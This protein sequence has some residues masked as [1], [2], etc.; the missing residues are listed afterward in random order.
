MWQRLDS[1]IGDKFKK[2][3]AVYDKN[4]GKKMMAASLRFMKYAKKVKVLTRIVEGVP[5]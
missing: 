4:Y 5:K 2:I 1:I 3:E